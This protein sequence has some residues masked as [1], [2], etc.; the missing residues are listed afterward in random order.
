MKNRAT[1]Y[2]VKAGY[3]NATRPPPSPP[4]GFT[5]TN[6]SRSS[7]IAPKRKS[8]EAEPAIITETKKQNAPARH[9]AGAFPNPFP[10]YQRIKL[11]P[12]A[13]PSL[14]N[15]SAF[16]TLTS[17][18][19]NHTIRL[20]SWNL[21]GQKIQHYLILSQLGAGGMGVVYCA[22]DEQLDRKVA[23]KVLSTGLLAD[24]QARKQFRQEALALA[25]LN[26][27]NIETV[28]AFSS[29]DGLD[30]LAMELIPGVPLNEK[31]AAGPLSEREVMR[32]GVQMCD[33]L[34][35]AH[36]QGVIHRDLKPANLFVT[37]EKRLKILDFGLAILLRSGDEVD[38][39]RSLAEIPGRVTGTLP[40]MSPEQLRGETIDARSD[41]YSAGAVMYEMATGKRAFPQSQTVQLM[42][43][44]LHQPP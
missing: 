12:A 24:D 13:H 33:G 22:L 3:V 35:A 18:D 9:R 32:L 41:I 38:I 4:P 16:C 31:L 11:P 39:T 17:T 43:A 34:A 8:A 37:P 28:Y 5:V 29:Q 40:Y 25:K 14:S 19:A 30:F 10:N 36:D 20:R 42:G 27:P 2:N 6:R 7:A 21:I 44:I 23:L 15:T 26:H 1:S